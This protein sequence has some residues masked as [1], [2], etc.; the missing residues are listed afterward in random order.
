MSEGLSMFEKWEGEAPAE[1][2][3]REGEAPAEPN[4]LGGSLQAGKC[5]L[6]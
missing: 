6:N 4:H 3:H 2:N 1:P 5:V